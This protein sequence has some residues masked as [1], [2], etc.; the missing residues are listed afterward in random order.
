MTMNK[1]VIALAAGALLAGCGEKMQEAKNVMEMA[2]SMQDAAKNIE[3]G[4]DEATKFYKER[5]EK[6]D[7][8]AMPYAELQK[9]LPTSVDGYTPAEA[10]GGS[11]QNMGG[12]SMSTAEQTFTGTAGADGNAPSIHV[13][14]VDYGGTQAGSAMMGAPM[15]MM[16]VSSDDAHQ[17]SGT[18]K[19]DVPY[20]WAAENYNKDSK[21]ASVTAI[22]RYRY[23][24]TVEA[25]NQSEDKSEMVK[26]LAADIAKKFEGK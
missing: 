15:M 11:S 18:L 12:F 17:R 4:Q 6:G 25:R 23:M 24:I 9:M 21:Q 14:L 20:T 2:E 13:T 19:L 1:L 22:T 3:E 5:Q 10:P 7:T 26:T 8:L 16:N